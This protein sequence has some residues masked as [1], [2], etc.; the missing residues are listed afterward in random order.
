[1]SMKW[2]ARRPVLLGLVTLGILVGGFGTW[3]V[4]VN[5]SGAVIASGQ[6]EVEQNRQI[7]QHPDGGVVE[8][9]NVTEGQ[10]VAAGD[11]L[12]RLDGNMLA[13][14]LSIVESQF[15][16][17]LARRGRLTAE[18]DGLDRITFPEELVRVAGERPE[19]DELMVGQ[20]RLYDARA[21]TIRQQIS[22]LDRRRDQIASQVEGI[23]AQN[24]ALTR[25]L[26]FI[27]EELG[28]QQTLFERGLAQAPRVLALQREEAR[29]E[30]QRGA[31]S[32]ELAQAEGRSTEIALQ[33]LTLESQR[34]EEAQTQLRDLGVRELELAERRRTLNERM[35]RLDIR[36]PVGGL[37][38]NL[39]VTTPRAVLRPAEPVLFLI[40]Q[41]RPLVIAARVHPADIDQ[42]YIGQET[43]LMFSGF[44]MRDTPE[45]TGRITRVSAD[46]FVDQ[47]TGQGFYRAEIV[48]S[49]EAVLAL[50][51]RPIVP[52]MPVDAFIRTA[53]RTPLHYLTEPLTAYITRAFRD[54]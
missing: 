9:I 52:G 6:V 39:Q 53:D 21:E 3:A 34:R 17:I 8:A 15:F 25:Q 33:I 11:V 18:R 54:G 4:M 49:P 23:R 40:P 2:S 27:L 46:A 22:Q 16:E 37:V 10:L 51:D 14:E 50:G 32:A 7:V 13:S 26:E 42:V 24:H 12:F 44:S 41:D 5:I 30:G 43:Q 20:H 1:M 29:L 35:D 45:L 36:A 31:L 47:T 28:A 19:V 38:Y 48:M